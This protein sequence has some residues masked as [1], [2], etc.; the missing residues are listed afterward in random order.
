MEPFFFIRHAGRH[1]KVNFADILF[2]EA[3]K[4]YCRIV[5]V[6]KVYVI[7]QRTSIS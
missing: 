2:V 7:H 6:K 1:E 3:W 5:L 4:N